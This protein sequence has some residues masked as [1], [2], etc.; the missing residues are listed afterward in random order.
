VK[1]TA[2]SRHPPEPD[3]S[4][5]PAGDTEAARLQLEQLSTRWGLLAS[6][7]QIEA[8]LRYCAE[9]LTWSLRINLTAAASLT[10]LATE[11]LPDAFALASRIRDAKRVIDV[12]S[13]GGLPAIPLALLC[14]T[15]SFELVEPTAKK[16]AFL[17]HAIRLLELSGR[18]TVCHGRVEAGFGGSDGNA[19]EP[20]DVAI[21]R[22]TFSP[23]RWLVLGGEL[24]HPGGRVFALSTTPAVGTPSGLAL[25]GTLAYHERR[26]LLEFRRST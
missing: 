15:S 25:E 6:S 19:Q 10:Q 3:P 21:S 16:V 11:H 7:G 8:L 9:L 24:V 12:G 22:A 4:P 5:R 1:K 18:V 20:F 17:R 13:G 2:V 14:G 26:F 23:E